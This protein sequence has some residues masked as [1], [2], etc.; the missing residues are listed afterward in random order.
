MLNFLKILFLKEKPFND[1]KEGASVDS[2]IS[3]KMV[4]FIRAEFLW[5]ASILIPVGVLIWV[6][7]YANSSFSFSLIYSVGLI[8]I[9]TVAYTSFRIIVYEQKFIDDKLWIEAMFIF[10]VSIPAC[11]F[12]LWLQSSVGPTGSTATWY[13]F[14]NQSL[15][16]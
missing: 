1:G 4:R 14:M 11:L 6:L 9:T 10:I 16:H 8:F 3:K 12:Y 2:A 15:G 13:F 7:S 5:V